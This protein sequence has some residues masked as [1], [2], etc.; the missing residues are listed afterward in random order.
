MSSSKEGS[1]LISQKAKV[2]KFVI[3]LKVDES[4]VL[5]PCFSC[6]R[7]ICT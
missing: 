5:N 7:V 1:L 3:P 2:S 6:T 4:A